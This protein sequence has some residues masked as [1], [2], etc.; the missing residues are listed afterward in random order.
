M[1]YRNFGKLNWKVSEIGYG[2]WGM[3]GWS[4]GE[5]KETELALDKS[6]ELGCNF[7][8]TAFAYGAGKSENI[9]AALLK[10][11]KSKRLYTATKIPPKNHQWPSIKGSSIQDVFPAQHI[12]DYTEKSLKNLG[13]ETI[14]L[15]QFHVWEDA[16]SIEEEWKLAIEKLKKE[17][18]IQGMGISVNRWEPTN[19]LKTLESGIIESIQVIYNLFDQNPEDELF[20]YCQQNNI[21]VI[22]RVPFDEG[23]L[24]GT[25]TKDSSWEKGDF[26]NLYFCKENLIPTIERVNALSKELPAK[27][28]LPELALRF[29]KH[30]PAVSTM[31]PGMRK[32]RNVENNMK[33]GF[34]KNEVFTKE[35]LTMTKKH[36]WDRIPTSWSH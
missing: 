13:V 21:A 26:R 24:T 17:G 5:D 30:H 20:P 12:I 33:I 32:I 35:I 2:M 15:Q 27:I 6:V 11:H 29:I 36:R 31:I 23:S 18:K 28:T 16:W 3:A 25:L 4:G 19:C 9:L 34:D 8:D 10:R 1:Q 7:F 22:A 14:D